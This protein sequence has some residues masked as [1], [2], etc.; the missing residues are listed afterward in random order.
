MATPHQ[1]I[2]RVGGWLSLVCA[3]HC[4][5]VPVVV[6]LAALGVPVASELA[7]FDDGRFELGFSVAAVIFVA[8]SLGLGQRGAVDRRPMLGGFAL[9][10]SLIA[11][12]HVCPGPDWLAHLVLVAGASI[13]ALTHHRSFRAHRPSSPPP[14]PAA[15]LP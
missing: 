2:D 14:V 8:V 12:S 6:L 11:G 10:L 7:V 3:L 4:A 1:T 15:L 9:G 5:V 13:V